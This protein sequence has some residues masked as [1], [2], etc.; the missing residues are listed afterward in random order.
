MP[1]NFLDA[2]EKFLISVATKGGN[3]G[4][5]YSEIS[6]VLAGFDSQHLL[7]VLSFDWKL[8]Y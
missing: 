5:Y 3:F 8:A 6:V 1:A 2:K 4:F 7:E